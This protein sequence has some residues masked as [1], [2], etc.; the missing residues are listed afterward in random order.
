MNVADG[1]FFSSR[2][3][4]CADDPSGHD[5]RLL[6]DPVP[7]KLES[8]LLGQSPGLKGNLFGGLDSFDFNRLGKV[9]IKNQA[10]RA[11]AVLGRGNCYSINR[12]AFIL[13]QCHRPSW[14]AVGLATRTAA[15]R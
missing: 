1:V 9:P 7:A 15:A 12:I 14:Y 8:M 4:A 6:I 13:F 3:A 5:G 2:L 10:P 11:P